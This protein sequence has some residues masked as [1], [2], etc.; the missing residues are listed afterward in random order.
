MRVSRIFASVAPL[1]SIVTAVVVQPSS[2]EFDIP[3]GYA[4]I[5]SCVESF[6]V[7]DGLAK[8]DTVDTLEG[9]INSVVNSGI[10]FDLLQEIA[11]SETQMDNLANVAISALGGNFTALSSSIGGLNITLNFTSIWKT[12]LGT[13][14][15]PSTF[16]GLLLN[17]TNRD[18][19]ATKIGEILVTQTWV[20]QLLIDLGHHAELSFD[21]IATLIKT[22]KSK[23]NGTRVIHNSDP[24]SEGTFIGKRS[25]YQGSAQAFAS[26]LVGQVV[27]SSFLS[28]TASDLLVALNRTGVVAP[29]VLKLFADPAVVTLIRTLAPKIYDSGALN[30]I[31]LND[32]YVKAKKQ[33]LLSD[34]IQWVFTVPVYSPALGLILKY[35]DMNGYYQQVQDSLYGPHGNSMTLKPGSYPP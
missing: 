15:I 35:L 29:I 27:G 31:P 33:N 20:N 17:D 18:F 11:S 1:L 34:A 28:L 12:I 9:V 16:D 22:I 7:Q 10:I 19:L 4:D 24:R 5:Q 21:N 32:I 3:Q 6:I 2:I 14:L 25:D 13:G 30:K 23:A 26:N 8:R